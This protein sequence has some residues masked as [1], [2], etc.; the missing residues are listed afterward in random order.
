RPYFLRKLL[1]RFHGIHGSIF[2]H[3]RA[4]TETGGIHDDMN[5]AGEC[6]YEFY[7]TWI[8]DPAKARENVEKITRST[9]GTAECP[10]QGIP[11]QQD[12]GGHK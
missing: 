9:P 7:K 5:G 8:T 10:I 3:F 4:S 1:T 12:N 6:P 11:N 2:S